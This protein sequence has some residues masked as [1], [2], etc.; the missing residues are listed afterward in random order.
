MGR[1][2]ELSYRLGRPW[3]ASLAY[4]AQICDGSNS[5][6]HLGYHNILMHPFHMLG[7]A[8]VFGWDA[9]SFCSTLASELDAATQRRILRGSQLRE[10]LKQA[11][12]Q[13]Y[14]ILQQVALIYTGTRSKILDDIPVPK[15]P[16]VKS[17]LRFNLGNSFEMPDC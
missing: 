7:V 5:C 4:S 11:P 9:T 10:L 13:L 6:V 2:W 8:G 3:I 1:E 14:P 15:L 17:L 16:D 12:R